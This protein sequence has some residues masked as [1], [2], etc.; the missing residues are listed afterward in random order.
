MSGAVIEGRSV[1]LEYEGQILIFELVSTL[2]A[3]HR[4]ADRTL[5][6]DPRQ[7]QGQ[8]AVSSDTAELLLLSSKL[9]L[10]RLHRARKL[11]YLYPTRTPCALPSIVQPLL[12][13]L[14]F[15][16]TT[17]EVEATLELF[18]STLQSA[19]LE[20]DVQR[21]FEVEKETG[22]SALQGLLKGGENLDVLSCAFRLKFEQRQARRSIRQDVLIADFFCS[23]GIALSL[24]VTRAA[25]LQTSRAAVDLSHPADL[26]SIVAEDLALQLAHVA[27]PILEEEL[28][29]SSVKDQ[30][31]LDELEGC[32]VAG[33]AGNIR[34]VWHS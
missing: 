13:I 6:C 4:G 2:P 11:R 17:S 1:K 24:P 26:A 33:R 23:H 30:V 8:A 29:E 25:R 3:L 34:S 22:T 12:R 7:E 5:Q 15:S 10:S 21:S 28:E 20:S 16:T 32:I 9:L 14:R 18:A 31:F 27:L 19:G